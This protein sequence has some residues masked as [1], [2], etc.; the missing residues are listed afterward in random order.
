MDLKNSL[1]FKTQYSMNLEV[2]MTVLTRQEGCVVS[3]L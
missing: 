1:T 3:G 2:E